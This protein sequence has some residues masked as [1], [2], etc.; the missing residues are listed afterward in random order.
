MKINNN[1]KDLRIIKKGSY[2]YEGLGHA[3]KGGAKCLFIVIEDKKTKEVWSNYMSQGGRAWLLRGKDL[4]KEKKIKRLKKELNE[5][6]V[7][8]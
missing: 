2:F 7:K 5:L 1:I 6:G 8:I 4:K 3:S